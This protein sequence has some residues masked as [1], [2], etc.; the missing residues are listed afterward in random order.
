MLC[1]DNMRLP[2][3]HTPPDRESRITVTPQSY[4]PH[5][6]FPPPDRN[7]QEGSTVERD[8][9]LEMA[10]GQIEKQYGQGAIMRL[11]E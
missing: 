7:Q 3:A 11:G 5:D 6:D 2:L 10:L 8:Q 9:A 4:G 1:A